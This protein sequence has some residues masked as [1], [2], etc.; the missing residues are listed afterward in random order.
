[1]KKSFVAILTLIA[2]VCAFCATGATAVAEEDWRDSYIEGNMTYYSDG[3]YWLGSVGEYKSSVAFDST[4]SVPGVFANAAE[5]VAVEYTVPKSGTLTFNEGWFWYAANGAANDGMGA[6]VYLNDTVVLERVLYT[7]GSTANIFA[8][9]TYSY[10]VNQGDVV[11]LVVDPNGNHDCDYMRIYS[12]LTLVP[13]DGSEPIAASTQAFN[14]TADNTEWSY[15]TLTKLNVAETGADVSYKYKVADMTWDS[16]NSMWAGTEPYVRVIKGS[17]Y[18][19][20]PGN[21]Q[22]VGL[23]YRV[24]KTGVLTFNQTNHM[25][26]CAGG[27]SS[28]GIGATVLFNGKIIME[29]TVVENGTAI[30]LLKTKCLKVNAGD[31]IV[32]MVD[33]N[34]TNDS[35]FANL[36]IDLSV[37][38]SDGSDTI[39]ANFQND[40]S[41]E[42]GGN[43]WYYRTYEESYAAVSVESS[44][45]YGPYESNPSLPEGCAA[46]SECA[47]FFATLEAKNV[48]VS[49]YGI[50]LV[51]G[52]NEYHF[53][54]DTVNYPANG[55]GQYGIA[56]YGMPKGEYTAYAYV[57]ADGTT[58]YSSTS[59]TLIVGE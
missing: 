5:S 17:Y 30:D 9:G 4:Y 59:C 45:Y 14:N 44:A 53:A 8:G 29:R 49:E 34:G 27:A 6:A 47:I 26:W 25:F 54:A 1:M 7:V 19:I 36:L 42:Q 31:E 32:F 58:V 35:D 40:F 12:S 10:P 18:G 33:S 55:N 23:V 48:T 57:V 16:E 21:T 46:D 43:N 11:Y 28:N 41:S 20:L 51:K 50:K 38:P 22:N 15:K 52:V 56:L 13:E 24:P 39:N 2:V 37:T 3:N